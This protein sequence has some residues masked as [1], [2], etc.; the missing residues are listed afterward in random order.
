MQAARVA[1]DK[2][3]SPDP[4]SLADQLTYALCAALATFVLYKIR[5]RIR[6]GIRFGMQFLAFA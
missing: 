3:R 6:N 5:Q 2:A 4:L 1:R